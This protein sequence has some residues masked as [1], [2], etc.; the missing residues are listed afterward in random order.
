MG[1]RS[2]V[3]LPVCTPAARP[4]PPFISLT[5]RALHT[6]R[7]LCLGSRSCPSDPYASLGCQ[8][9]PPSVPIS[10]PATCS[11]RPMLVGS[12]T[13]QIRDYPPPPG[14]HLTEGCL[15][16]KMESFPSV[17]TLVCFPSGTNPVQSY[18]L[19]LKDRI[20]KGTLLSPRVPP[21]NKPSSVI[22]RKTVM[23]VKES[24]ITN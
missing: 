19:E 12:S 13:F 8:L 16:Q 15:P 4:A 17:G 1:T 21:T 23:V 10:T 20:N 5:E 11:P 2:R 7:S 22:I 18:N 14:D 24:L 9:S 6:G 3:D